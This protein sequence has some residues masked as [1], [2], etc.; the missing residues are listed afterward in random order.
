MGKDKKVTLRMGNLFCA[1]EAVEFFLV[2]IAKTFKR[3]E[4]GSNMILGI[5]LPYL[6]KT[7][8][9]A[10]DGSWRIVEFD[11]IR[12]EIAVQKLSIFGI[13]EGNFFSLKVPGQ[14]VYIFSYDGKTVKFE[15]EKEFDKEKFLSS[16][17]AVLE[18]KKAALAAQLA[19]KKE[20]ERMERETLQRTS[21]KPRVFNLDDVSSEAV[22]PAPAPIKVLIPAT[23]AHREEFVWDADNIKKANAAADANRDRAIN[24]TAPAADKPTVAPKTARVSGDTF[25]IASAIGAKVGTPPKASKMSS[26]Q[27]ASPAKET[28]PA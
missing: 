9:N 24:A 28:A 15:T 11:D 12:K 16:S 10:V 5:F 7:Q 22:I 13:R 18:E 20:K 19:E 23:K 21:S 14:G 26:T 4:Y 8:T 17:K 1:V 6:T 2:E 3:D 27:A 25:S